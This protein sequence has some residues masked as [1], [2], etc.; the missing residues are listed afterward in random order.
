[1]MESQLHFDYRLAKKKTETRWESDN[2]S[3]F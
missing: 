2:Y 3:E 1:M